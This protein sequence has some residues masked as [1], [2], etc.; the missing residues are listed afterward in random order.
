MESESCDWGMLGKVRIVRPAAGGIEAEGRVPR[1]LELFGDHF[2]GFPVLPGVLSLE[3]MKKAAQA[4]LEYGAPAATGRLREVRSIK[5]G[6]FLRPG[7]SWR[8]SLTPR[9]GEAQTVFQGRLMQEEKTA[10]SA[11]LVFENSA[12]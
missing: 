1:D 12:R 11:V 2:P 9:P 10:V 3:L 7:D 5:F 8:L 4:W 6:A